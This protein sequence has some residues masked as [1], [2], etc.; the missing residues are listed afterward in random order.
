LGDG[1]VSGRLLDERRVVLGLGANLG[2][3]LGAL[4]RA[5]ALL[6]ASGELAVAARSSVYE[7]APV[8]PAQPS[9]L[10]AA[11]AVRT[12]LSLAALLERALGVER[13]LGRVR[14]DA[15]RWGPRTIDVDLLWAE[16]ETRDT[17][18][19]VVPHPRLRERPFALVPLVEVAPDACDPRTAERYADL[20][21]GRE[22][23]RV[24][25]L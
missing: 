7:T 11:V 13:A 10:N 2:D 1:E 4:R 3:R 20:C 17:G 18:D 19:L 15:V 14:P 21:T 22:L 25:R 23:V 5:V 6:A 24:A 8:G 9:F 12:R 16:G